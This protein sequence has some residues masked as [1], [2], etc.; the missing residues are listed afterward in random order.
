MKPHLRPAPWAGKS[1]LIL[2]ED[3]RAI[4]LGIGLMLATLIAYSMGSNVIKALT[5]NP[6]GVKRTSFGQLLAHFRAN[7]HLLR[8]L[9]LLVWLVIF[10]MSTKI[11]GLKL[12]QFIPSFIIL[13]ILSIIMFSISGWAN[14]A[15]YNLEPP[16]VALI[17]GL[18]LANVIPLPK[19]L[20]SGF[21][22]N[23]TLKPGLFCSAP[24][25]PSP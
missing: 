8:L 24:L 9:Q 21:G 3:R 4:H 15:K 1:L 14:A 11:M 23:T 13:Y 16:L 6:G 19:W 10:S 17:I 18:I 2:K 5:I 7:F 25:F 20:D 22:W 12:S